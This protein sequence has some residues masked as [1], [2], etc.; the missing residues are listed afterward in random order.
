[1]SARL[2]Y[3]ETALQGAPLASHPSS[4]ESQPDHAPA[5]PQ[6]PQVGTVRIIGADLVAERTAD[7]DNFIRFCPLHQWAARETYSIDA[8]AYQ[9]CPACAFDLD[10][11]RGRVRYRMLHMRL[12]LGQ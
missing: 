6:I 7:G 2:L 3:I 8:T 5:E 12:A 11:D 10:G 9:Q 1:M 4:R